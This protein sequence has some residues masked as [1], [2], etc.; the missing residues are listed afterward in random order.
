MARLREH[1]WKRRLAALAIGCLLIAS[2][3]VGCR[4]LGLGVPDST[5]DPAIQFESTRPLFALDPFSNTYATSPE[6][7]RYFVRDRFARKKGAGTFRIFCL[8]GSTVQGRPYSIE[9]AFSTWLKLSLQSAYP[10]RAFEVVNAGGVS[11]ASYRLIPI[12]TECLQYEPDL[13]IVCTGQNEFLEART[14]ADARRWEPAV[15]LASQLHLYHLI[16]DCLPS[17]DSITHARP[18]LKREVDALLDYQGGLRGYTRDPIWKARV[19]DHFEVNVQ[20]LV[21]LAQQAE[22]PLIM[23]RPPVN[24]KD[25]PPFKSDGPALAAYHNGQRALAQNDF[26]TAETAFWNALEEDLCPLRMLPE[27]ATRL[28][29]ICHRA[30]VPLIDAQALL[31]K[32]TP[33]GLLGN[34]ILVDHVHPTFRGHQE[35]ANAL[36]QTLRPS[37]GEPQPDWP[38]RR[39]EA[40]QRHLDGLDKL[41]YAH[42]RQRLRNLRLWT[43]G[44]TDGPRFQPHS[45]STKR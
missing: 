7:L 1:P 3:E 28:G 34:E 33:A 12:L 35:I 27:M 8:G 18:I 22:I 5:E 20:R 29:T 23:I 39:A 6:R 19:L 10:E 43:Q 11:Y 16:N 26:A 38:A 2:I 40:Y 36:T 4:L 45:P 37:L 44:R 21:T 9:T 41:Y 14:Y 25:C 24:L 13:L 31:G 32:T 30:K 17:P 15:K 42:G